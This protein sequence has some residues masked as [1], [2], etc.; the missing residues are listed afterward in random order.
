MSFSTCLGIESSGIEDIVEGAYSLKGLTG[1]ESA[2]SVRYANNDTLKP[3]KVPART[4]KTTDM[5]ESVL[6][7]LLAHRGFLE[8]VCTIGR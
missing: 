5:K 2:Y 6:S 7:R 4:P 1:K 8:G 3:S